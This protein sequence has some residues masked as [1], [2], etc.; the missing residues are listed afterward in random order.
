MEQHNEP[1]V[2]KRSLRLISCELM[3]RGTTMKAEVEHHCND[4][5]ER[6]R[7][8]GSGQQCRGNETETVDGI[9][10]GYNRKRGVKIRSRIFSQSTGTELLYSE[11][12]KI[13]GK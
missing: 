12:G 2:L 9:D 10:I 11:M 7:W 1:S 13:R 3:V 4:S 5:G 6:R 8:L